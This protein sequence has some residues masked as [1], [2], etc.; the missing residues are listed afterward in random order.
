[1]KF[2]ID[3]IIK[4]KKIERVKGIFSF[5]PRTLKKLFIYSSISQVGFCFWLQQFFHAITEYPF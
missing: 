1:M 2:I 3:N 5:V 4:G